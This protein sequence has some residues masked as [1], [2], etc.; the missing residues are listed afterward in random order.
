MVAVLALLLVATPERAEAQFCYKCETYYISCT[1]AFPIFDDPY[2]GN[3]CH[4]Q[5]GIYCGVEGTC[6]VT[7]N[8]FIKEAPQAFV[9]G[10][11]SSIE[12]EMLSFCPSRAAGKEPEPRAERKSAI[13]AMARRLL[14]LFG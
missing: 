3:N 1:I 13:A 12:L 11:F 9:A 6:V 5:V 14:S 10:L 2:I 8:T 4:Q 7:S